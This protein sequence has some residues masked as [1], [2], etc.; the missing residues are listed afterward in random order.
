MVETVFLP[1]VILRR[2]ELMLDKQKRP[3]SA[4]TDRAGKGTM[5]PP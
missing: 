2:P 3:E 1:L 5:E 4:G